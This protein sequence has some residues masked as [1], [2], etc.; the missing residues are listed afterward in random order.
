V[1]DSGLLLVERA[2]EV[3]DLHIVYSNR[4][5]PEY[6]TYGW[7]ENNPDSSS[8]GSVGDVIYWSKGY[9][10]GCLSVYLISTIVIHVIPG[11]NFRLNGKTIEDTSSRNINIWILYDHSPKSLNIW[12]V[13][14]TIKHRDIVEIWSSTWASLAAWIQNW[15]F[16]NIARSISVVLA[17]QGYFG[18]KIS[19]TLIIRSC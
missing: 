8:L 10:E 2:L 3:W 6:Y 13:I 14:S 16:A 15:N 7:W 18:S 11:D 19:G 17:R 9:K 4:A 5:Q 1:C 12:I